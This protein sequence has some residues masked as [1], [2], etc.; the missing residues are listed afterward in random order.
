MKSTAVIKTLVIIVPLL[1]LQL[2]RS[3]TTVCLAEDTEAEAASPSVEA[4]AEPAGTP[5]ET[6]AETEKA[7]EKEV[8]LA[9][10]HKKAGIE[11]SSCHKETP[12]AVETPKDICLTCHANYKDVAASYIDPHNAH[13][14]FERCSDCH[15]AHKKS[16]SQCLQCHTFNQQTP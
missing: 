16:E 9:D 7:A 8:L 6:S 1:F 12:P 14:E 3:A 15:H 2:N 5:D 4:P 10:T 13:T 11:C